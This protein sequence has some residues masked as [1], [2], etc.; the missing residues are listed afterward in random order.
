MGWVERD[1]SWCV[2][3]GVTEHRRDELEL[4]GARKRWG[5]S[6]EM[7]WVVRGKR[8]VSRAGGVHVPRIF[9]CAGEHQSNQNTNQHTGATCDHSSQGLWTSSQQPPAAATRVDSS[10]LGQRGRAVLSF[11]RP[12][13][14]KI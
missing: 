1:E 7:G 13:H 12:L 8:G 3:V 14:G 9:R 6:C 4:V 10:R 11:E 2:H 5:E